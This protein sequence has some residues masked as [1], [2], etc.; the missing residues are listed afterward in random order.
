[1]VG[2]ALIG[3]RGCCN[4]GASGETFVCT[5]GC[6]TGGVYTGVAGCVGCIGGAAGGVGGLYTGTGGC[7]GVGCG[8]AGFDVP[9]IIVT[10]GLGMTG[11]SWG[12]G[13]T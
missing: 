5:V 7:L 10:E 4:V 8:A 3:W 12:T 13:G 6:C 2:F 9:G 11:G 1:M